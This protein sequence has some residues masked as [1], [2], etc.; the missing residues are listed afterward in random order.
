MIAGY[1]TSYSI[2]SSELW[3]DRLAKNQFTRIKIC[4]LHIKWSLDMITGNG[5]AFRNQYLRK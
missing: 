2:S 4:W 3:I 1:S 5:I